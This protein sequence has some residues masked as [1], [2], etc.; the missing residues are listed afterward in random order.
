MRYKDADMIGKQ[1]PLDLHPSS[2]HEDIHFYTS[3][4]TV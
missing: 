4:W 2:R 3:Y 1:L